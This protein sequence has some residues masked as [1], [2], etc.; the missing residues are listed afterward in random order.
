LPKGTTLDLSNNHLTSLPDTFPTL[1]H[2]VR[3]DLSKN[4][5]LELPEF[6]GH[7]KSLK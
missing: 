5:I 6:F 7:L 1:T 4:R 3:L 2:L